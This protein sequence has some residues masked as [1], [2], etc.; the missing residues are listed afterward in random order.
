MTED[1]T[2]AEATTGEVTA[3][4]TKDPVA[5]APT[6]ARVLKGNPTNEELAALVLVIAAASGGEDVG[7]QRRHVGWGDRRRLQTTPADR[8]LGWGG[9]P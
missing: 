2:Q 9:R 6:I 1:K 4:E 3:T 8:G 7:E 5:E